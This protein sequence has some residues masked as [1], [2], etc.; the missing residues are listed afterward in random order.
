MLEEMRSLALDFLFKSLGTGDPPSDLHKWF[1]QIRQEKSSALLPFL[2][3]AGD[4]I[5]RVYILRPNKRDGSQQREAD[6][7]ILDAEDFTKDKQSR[8]P[9]VSLSGAQSA[10]V[11]PIIKRT[12]KVKEK[13]P[14]PSPKILQTNLKFFKEV[15]Q[16]GK[17]WSDYFKEIVEILNAKQLV[18]LP[19]NKEITVGEGNAYENSLEAAVH[20]IDER[21][22]VYLIV[23][24]HNE[25]WPGDRPDYLQYLFEDLPDMRYV[26]KTSGCPAQEG[27]TCPLCGESNVTVYPNAVK[28]AGINLAN[29]DR[30]GAFPGVATEMAWKG[31]ALCLD[32]ADLLSIYKNHVYKQFLGEVAG[33]R[34]LL[35]PLTGLDGKKRQK[36]IKRVERYVPATK[37]GVVEQEEHLLSIMAEEPAVTNLT[38]LWAKFG[39][40]IENL[41]GVI[42]DV[43]PSRLGELS[44]FNQEANRWQHA[45]FPVYK[46][47]RFDL[48]L[49]CLGP[50]FKRPGGKKAKQINASQRLFQLKRSIA[51]ALY[52][53]EQLDPTTFWQ[54]INTT[55]RWYLT[56]TLQ[57][58]DPRLKI[59]YLLKEDSPKTD[60]DPY[61]TMAGWIR[62]VALLVCYLQRTEVFPMTS[63]SYEPRLDSLKPYFGNESGIDTKDKAFAFLL[64]VLYGKVMRVQGGRGVNVAANA[65]TWLKRLTL[66]G[67]DLPEL[68][69]N[70]RRKL[71]VYGSE[72]NETVRAFIHEL[73]QLGVRV[74]NRIQLDETTT[75]YFLLLG[76]S[77]ST[78]ILPPPKKKDSATE[79]KGENQ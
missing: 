56:N 50:L 69:I 29:M 4:K 2:V 9:F 46:Q 16:S 61:L 66:S 41:R 11:G 76:Q 19:T 67:N 5:E 15:S 58:D 75:C 31:Y 8:V 60:K 27:Q 30:P 33:E 7:I 54:E 63:N 55:A 62:H 18:I 74:G 6:S 24:D 68:Y 14:G 25:K 40:N 52:R 45:M 51:A 1:R 78:T 3:E 70:V 23:A 57:F 21:K 49:S 79:T 37:K 26:T 17:L 22:T 59:W 13:K 34:A 65:L 43:F 32:C 42:T 44:K 72:S 20:E 39:Q 64:G 53:K 48:G 71:L 47:A 36:F 35:L 12:F 38:I 73:G 28:G 10:A 77:L